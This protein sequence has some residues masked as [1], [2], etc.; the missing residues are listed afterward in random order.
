MYFTFILQSSKAIFDK[1]N[2]GENDE[3]NE[4]DWVLSQS[5]DF[6]SQL[7]HQQL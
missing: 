6:K 4:I 5:S 7:H 2:K 1:K 3:K